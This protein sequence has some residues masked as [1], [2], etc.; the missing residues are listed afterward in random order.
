[1]VC[2]D[3]LLTGCGEPCRLAQHQPVFSIEP[4]LASVEL[5]DGSPDPLCS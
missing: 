4:C 1:M 2:L 5:F 3:Y